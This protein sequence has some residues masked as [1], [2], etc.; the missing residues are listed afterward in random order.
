MTTK[1]SPRDGE[2]LSAYLDGQLAPRERADLERRLRGDPLLRA[3]LVELHR[4]RTVL[5]SQPRLRAPRNFMLT[6]QMVGMP[7]RRTPSLYPTLRLASAL[8][9]LLFVVLLVGD[10]LTA[11]RQTAIPQEANLAAKQVEQAAPKRAV[12]PSIT[13]E[14]NPGLAAAP[15]QPTPLPESPTTT[16][17]DTLLQGAEPPTEISPPAAAGGGPAATETTPSIAAAGMQK[18]AEAGQTETAQAERLNPPT[19][20]S[21]MQMAVPVLPTETM[22]VEQ[23]PLIPTQE[24]YPAP[25]LTPTLEPTLTPTPEPTET[26]TLEPTVEPTQTA[27]LQPTQGPTPYVPPQPEVFSAQAQPYPTVSGPAYPQVE[28]RT[29]GSDRTILRVFEVSIALLAVAAGLIAIYLR[30]IGR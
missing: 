25:I 29:R 17:A 28:Q 6:P 19:P 22:S 5:R 24:L 1:I 20:T 8:A 14:T 11:P 12:A 18:L 16:A 15:Q 23:L 21:L 3:A 13:P 10:I 7:R 2:L 27:T 9:G 26:S 30:R 4:T